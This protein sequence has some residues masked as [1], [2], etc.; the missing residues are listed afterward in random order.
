M[1]SPPPSSRAHLGN[2][3][4]TK[5]LWM[6]PCLNGVDGRQ[7]GKRGILNSCFVHMGVWMHMSFRETCEP[8]RTGFP[9]AFQKGTSDIQIHKVEKWFKK[10]SCYL[11]CSTNTYWTYSRS[12]I[13]LEVTICSLYALE[14]NSHFH[15][16]SEHWAQYLSTQDLTNIGWKKYLVAMGIFNK[17]GLVKQKQIS[18]VSETLK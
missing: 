4:H 8:A 17:S 15:F 18:R 11:R 14:T 7:T 1:E 2:N 13:I 10:R 12:G 9:G 6:V 5:W 16:I 3:L